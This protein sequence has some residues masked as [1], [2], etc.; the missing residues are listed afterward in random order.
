M[1]LQQ[2]LAQLFPPCGEPPARDLDFVEVFAGEAAISRAL[3]CCDL[4]GHSLDVR[5]RGDHDVL[6]P[7]GFL[8]LAA[9][10][11]RL[12]PGGLLWAAPPCSSW[13][14]MSL[15]NTGRALSPSGDPANFRVVSQNALVERLL[16]LSA[17]VRARGCVFIWEQ[18]SSS[19]MLKYAPVAAFIGQAPDV[20][21]VTLDMGAFG[22]LAEK[23]TLL[24]GNAPYLPTLARRMSRM[25]KVHLN[26][27]TDRMLTANRWV[28]E[29]GRARCQGAGDLKATQAYP[30]G[31]GAA[32]ALAFTAWDGLV[33]TTEAPPL[34][35]AA[36]PWFLKDLK[37]PGHVWET[38]AAERK[39]N[40]APPRAG[41][42]RSP[43]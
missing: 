10:V 6:T 35:H 22:L 37:D 27:R 43:A 38:D 33:A 18:P 40:V 42:S 39:F 7:R 12:R 21:T 8:H 24:F 25:D 26:L 36:D 11:A 14:F 41:R 20:Q 9:S 23:Q 2:L 29:Q 15:P 32:H 1:A 4:K 13:I 31:F 5:Y 28:D 30:L 3:E 34:L 17:F 16:L 19:R